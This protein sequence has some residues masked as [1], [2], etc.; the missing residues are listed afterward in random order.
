MKKMK[1]IIRKVPERNTRYLERLLPDAVVVNDVNHNGCIW[2]FLKAIETAD[3]D[4]VYIQDDM[5]LCKDFRKKSEEYISKYPSDV[6]VFSTHL[7]KKN[8]QKG[9]A[10][11]V[12]KNGFN[13][14]GWRRDVILLSTYIP[15]D[16]AS[17]FMQYMLSEECKKNRFFK[18]CVANKSDDTFFAFF[19]NKIGKKVYMTIPNLAGHE[20]NISVAVNTRPVRISPDFDYKNCEKKRENEK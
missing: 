12:F 17:G 3:D 6:I 14:V 11:I 8:L 16:I 7:P 18:F 13:D 1:Y 4:A 19:L 5:L 20:E 9:N 2:S 15:K 10:E